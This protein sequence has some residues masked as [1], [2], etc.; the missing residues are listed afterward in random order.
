MQLGT[1]EYKTGEHLGAVPFPNSDFRSEMPG[2]RKQIESQSTPPLAGLS[3]FPNYEKFYH[4]CNETKSVFLDTLILIHGK[5]ETDKVT[6]DMPNQKALLKIVDPGASYWVGNGFHVRNLFPSTGL[7]A[8]VNPFLLLD[9]AGPTSFPPTALPQGVEEHPHRGFETVTICYQGAVAHRDSSGNAGIIGPGD[10]QWMTAASGVVHEEK[11]EAEFARRG[12]VLEMIQLWVNLP[13]V[14]KMDPPR[15]QTIL[16]RAI[17]AVPVDDSG[18]VVRVIAGQFQGRL[19]AAQTFSPI[20]LLDLHWKAGAM[21]D[22][23]ADGNTS[24]FLLKG[25]LLINGTETCRGEAKLALFSSAGS[26]ITLEA[27]EDSTALVLNGQPID[28]PVARQG[29]FV[30][31][32]RHELMQAVEDYRAGKMGHLA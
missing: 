32:T 5:I 4:C 8:E 11:H 30:M 26:T 19:G 16:S 23:P 20:Q 3:K 24:V 28:E 7:E 1:Y 18:S 10:V 22:L 14:H 29:P 13:R 31:N 9:Y 12:G 21:A 25:A 6:A 27:L 17:P 2:S 15:Y